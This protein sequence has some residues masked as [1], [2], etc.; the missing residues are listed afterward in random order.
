MTKNETRQRAEE[1]E[2]R[3]E[4]E[5]DWPW[6]RLTKDVFCLSFG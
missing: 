3:E 2:R 6:K 5:S 1:M 4:A